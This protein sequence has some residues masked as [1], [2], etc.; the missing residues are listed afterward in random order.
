LLQIKEFLTPNSH[1]LTK[2][3]DFIIIGQGLAGTC[4]ASE[5]L[6]RGKT[7]LVFDSP[8]LPSSSMVAGGLFNPI[9]GRNMV[10]TWKAN[11]LFPFLQRFYKNLENKLGERFIYN[12]PL[13]RPFA[14]NEE[15]NGWQGK[16]TE[17]RY[18]PFFEF[19]SSE[20]YHPDYVKNDLGGIM[21]GQTGYLNT[22]VLLENFRLLLKG[23]EIIV[24]EEFFPDKINFNAKSVVYKEYL[25]SKIILC[26]G[27]TGF[28]NQLLD[29]IRF[30]PLKGEVLHL[31]INYSSNFILNRNG[32]ILPRDGNYV[33][34]SNYDLTGT[35]WQTT[36]D[37]RDEIK[38]K[39]DKILNIDYEIVDQKA[40]L[41]PT[42]H[43]RRPVIGLIPKHP[44]I[45]VFNGLGTKGVSLAPYFA[46]QFAD[47]LINGA[48]IEQEVHIGRFFK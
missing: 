41:R 32:F 11:I 45:G 6:E 39:I 5:L 35:D 19:I 18:A 48:E 30:H 28:G 33:A 8:K 47:Y 42:T 29:N 26:D 36:T 3:Y 38:G 9:S 12:L 13:Y 31:N 40:G 17:D 22:K 21:L 7:V 25:A 23:K 1:K 24:E 27:P 44:Q 46:H 34:G 4:L 15:L 14:T 16:S 10:L 43:D 37:A 20:P 2:E